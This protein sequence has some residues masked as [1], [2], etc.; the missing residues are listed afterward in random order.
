MD[1]AKRE[2]CGAGFHH[3]PKGLFVGPFLL[4][5][6][7]TKLL[8]VCHSTWNSSDGLDLWD[9]IETPAWSRVGLDAARRL[10]EDNDVP[11]CCI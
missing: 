5:D 7:R 3:P 9:S 6:I 10:A 1:C 8:Y 4:E 2:Q 11:P